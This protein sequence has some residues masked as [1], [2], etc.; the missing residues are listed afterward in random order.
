[1]RVREQDTGQELLFA[2]AEPFNPR[3]ARLR[4]HRVG[5]DLG[6]ADDRSGLFEFDAKQCRVT[7]DIDLVWR[8]ARVLDFESALNIDMRKN[9]KPAQTLQQIEALQH[10]GLAARRRRPALHQIEATMELS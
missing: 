1:M 4:P 5:I 9:S 3:L 8:A 2:K 10:G 7:E 6:V